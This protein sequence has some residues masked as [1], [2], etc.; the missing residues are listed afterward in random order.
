MNIVLSMQRGC[1][2]VVRKG[3][4]F[5]FEIP[6]GVERHSRKKKHK[7]YVEAFKLRLWSSFML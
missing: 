6:N 7:V 3:E 2:V 5:R 4:A 1:D